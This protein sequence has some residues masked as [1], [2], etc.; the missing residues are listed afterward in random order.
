METTCLT[1]EQKNGER[2]RFES[3]R[4]CIQHAST[5]R[6]GL[7]YQKAANASR[8]SSDQCSSFS[9]MKGVSRVVRVP[10]L[11]NLFSAKGHL[12]IYSIIHGSHKINNLKMSLLYRFTEF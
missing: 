12:N 3:S 11:G 7:K 8:V 9:F 6:K 4:S 5:T 10:G 1:Q 2:H